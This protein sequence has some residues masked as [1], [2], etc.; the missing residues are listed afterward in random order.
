MNWIDTIKERH[1]CDD[2]SVTVCSVD[3]L[4]MRDFTGEGGDGVFQGIAT[5]GSVDLD[6]EVVEPDGLDWTYAL[7]F[8]AMYPSHGGYGTDPVAKL[9]AA[10]RKGEG[11]YFRGQFLKSSEFARQW[12]ALCKEMGSFGVSIG[13]QAIDR[14]RPN[15]DEKKKYG[16]HSYYIASARVLEL[17]PTFM[18]A[19]PDAIAEFVGKG[20]MALTDDQT[21]TLERMVKAGRVS[22]RLA[23]SIGYT[24][25]RR[26][27]VLL[28]D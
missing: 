21:V 22:K 10:K 28:S 20:K 11:W 4:T 17:S 12:H 15:D 7:K 8:K 16:P 19:N 1:G 25:K 24:A 9:L 6:D 14:R 5:T 26:T 3:G 2:V 18:P 13:F 23:E 27:I